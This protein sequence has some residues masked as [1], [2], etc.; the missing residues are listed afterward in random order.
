MKKPQSS[1]NANKK[2]KAKKKREGVQDYYLPDSMPCTLK[3]YFGQTWQ[4]WCFE[5]K[6]IEY[7]LEISDNGRLWLGMTMIPLQNKQKNL[8]DVQILCLSF[9]QTWKTNP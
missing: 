5:K 8:S 6:Q 7:L 1:N 9:Y 2:I 3:F 4:L